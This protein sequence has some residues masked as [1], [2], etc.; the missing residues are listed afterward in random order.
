MKKIIFLCVF[1]ATLFF[2]LK[3]TMA[4][5]VT[6]A[7]DNPKYFTYFGP[8]SI[9]IDSSDHPHIAY[10]GDHLYYAYHDGS[11]WHY[12]TI[13]SSPDVGWYTSLALDSEN[14]V[15]ISYHDSTNDDLKY[16]TVPLAPG[17]HL[18][19]LTAVVM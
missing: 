16:V 2:T 14:N 17:V 19:L 12:E 1:T 8:R 11:T 13:D 10:G 7:V 5:W 18:R 6:E 3:A 9:A 15:H 4:Q